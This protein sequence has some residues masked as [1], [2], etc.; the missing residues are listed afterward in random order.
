MEA[1]IASQ[2]NCT[3]CDPLL[4][5]HTSPHSSYFTTSSLVSN[6]NFT[7]PPELYLARRHYHGSPTLPYHLSRCPQSH[8]H[9]STSFTTSP[10]VPNLSLLPLSYTSLFATLMAPQ[11][12]LP[13]SKIPF[14][15]PSYLSF[16]TASNLQAHWT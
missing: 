8:F 9:F 1:P 10:I 16:L 11:S 5:S 6:P 12:Q 15:S 13:V 7:S 2:H 14:T 3:E 4:L